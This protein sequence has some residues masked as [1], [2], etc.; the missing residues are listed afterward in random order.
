M[1]N[2]IQPEDAQIGDLV[3]LSCDWSIW[4]ITE[5]EH[6]ETVPSVN[7]FAVE[8][9]YKLYIF[10]TIHDMHMFFRRN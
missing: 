10:R 2:T 1:F 8:N 7:A 6:L 3:V 9:G 5:Q 4:K